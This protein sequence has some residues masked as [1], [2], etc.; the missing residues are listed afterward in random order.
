[1]SSKKSS[2]ESGQES[3]EQ[4][5]DVPAYNQGVANTN[6]GSVAGAFGVVDRPELLDAPTFDVR[7]THY[8]DEE[9]RVAVDVSI[10][11]MK[12]NAALSPSQARALSAQLEEAATFAEVGDQ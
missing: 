8:T 6:I 5:D 11:D 12:I 3:D 4:T 7:A 10:G 9:S 1:M 2:A